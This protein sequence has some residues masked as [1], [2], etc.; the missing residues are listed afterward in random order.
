MFR[1]AFLVAFSG[2]TIWPISA[3]TQTLD[4]G[5]AAMMADG[6]RKQATHEIV[7]RSPQAKIRDLPREGV[8]TAELG[9]V[10][11]LA[12]QRFAGSASRALLI[13]HSGKLVLERYAPGKVDPNSTP[14]GNS[15]SK[16]LVSLAVGKALC[17]GA[18]PSLDAQVQAIVP[19]LSG[20]S[21]GD[22]TISDL[23]RM[24]SGAFYSDP[25]APTGWKNDA[26]IRLNRAIYSR[27][28]NTSFLDL[29]RQMDSRQFR[30]GSSFNYNNYDTV[31]LNIAV[32][33]ATG[34]KFSKFFEETV[35]NEVGPEGRGAWITNQSGE[36]AGYFGFSATSRDWLRV[37]MY[38]VEALGRSDCFGGYLKAATREQV[39]ANWPIN[40]SYGYQIWTN[41]TATAGTFCF[42]GNHGQQLIIR[43][44]TQSVLYVHA[45]DSRTN[46]LWRDLFDMLPG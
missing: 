4:E 7:E 18:I 17:A 44:A 15:M 14:I 21:W 2:L 30:P 23:L 10:L 16:S 5:I 24:T 36:V 41:C 34:R 20:T 37:G 46:R 28:L 26:D 43:P 11:D 8:R 29:M 27:Q 12:E 39:V 25:Q 6:W 45:I 33:R 40:K 22:S 19:Q 13:T 1:A 3:A 38:M 42:I 31:A 35:W 32:E 9:R